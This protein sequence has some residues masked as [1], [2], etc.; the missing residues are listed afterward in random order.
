MAISILKQHVNL[1]QIAW[2]TQGERTPG[3]QPWST[4]NR[5][6]WMMR[7]LQRIPNRR[8]YSGIGEKPGKRVLQKP[9]EE[10]FR[11]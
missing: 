9:K 8:K 6:S 5:Y 2:V 1:V 11:A 3:T 4:Q 10:S 7:N